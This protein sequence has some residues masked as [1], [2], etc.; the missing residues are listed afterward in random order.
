[1]PAVALQG[2]PAC[3]EEYYLQF[4]QDDINTLD[5]VLLQPTRPT[6][7][8]Y[9]GPHTPTRW[10][11]ST[12]V[13]GDQP[14]LIDEDSLRPYDI[15]CGRCRTA[16]NN[17]GNRRFRVTI[18]ANVQRY[19]DAPRRADKKVVITSIEHALITEAGARF[20]KRAKG[21]TFVQISKKEARNKIQQ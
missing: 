11:K 20:L 1:M 4:S 3:G 21:G 7:R 16:F 6:E 19:M 13:S 12:D 2:N 18:S 9:S 8:N 5:S 14:E 15:I 10:T 17:V